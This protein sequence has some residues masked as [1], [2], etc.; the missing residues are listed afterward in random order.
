RERH[1]HGP[2]AERGRPTTT[3][4][5]HPPR[6]L[7][8]TGTIRGGRRSAPLLALED[9]QAIE[10]LGRV[11][12]RSPAP[13]VRGAGAGISTGRA[14]RWLTVGG[15]AKRR[16]GIRFGGCDELDRTRVSQRLSQHE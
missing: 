5:R 16:A 9:A 13:R 8:V 10:L 3:D 4:A 15:A 1:S 11:R 7:F 6:L 2:S 12:P 14:A